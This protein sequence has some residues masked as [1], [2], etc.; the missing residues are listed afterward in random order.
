MATDWRNLAKAALLADG[1]IDETEVKVLRK[2]FYAD[3]VIDKIEVD[4]L[5]ELR[6]DAKSVTLAL[7]GLYDECMG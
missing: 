5:I 7:Q 3:G 4:F 1:V 6:N 2:I